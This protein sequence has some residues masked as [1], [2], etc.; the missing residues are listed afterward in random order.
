MRRI[1][2]CLPGIDGIVDIGY[3]A[4]DPEM[5]DNQDIVVSEG[6]TD[7]DVWYVF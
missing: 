2:C 4:D 5:E 6:D 3:P 7:G 1:S